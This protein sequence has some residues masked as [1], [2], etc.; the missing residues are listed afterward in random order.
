LQ[1]DV[2]DRRETQQLVAKHVEV[3]DPSGVFRLLHG[4]PALLSMA[5]VATRSARKH[6]PKGQCGLGDAPVAHDEPKVY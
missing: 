1:V 6:E 2:A 4:G 5:I 3:A